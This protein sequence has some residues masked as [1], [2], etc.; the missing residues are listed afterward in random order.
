MQTGYNKDEVSRSLSVE[1]VARQYNIKLPNKTNGVIKCPLHHHDDTTPSFSID[2]EDGLWKSFGCDHSG[3]LYT[4]IAEMENLDVIDDFTYVLEKAADIAGVSRSETA[5]GKRGDKRQYE[6]EWKKTEKG[7]LTAARSVYLSKKKIDIAALELDIRPNGES[8]FTIPIRNWRGE[9]IGLQ[10]GC[11]MAVSG[12]NA[13]GFFFEKIN[14]KKPLYVV[15]GLSDYL[16][17]IASGLRNTIGLFSVNTPDKE[18]QDILSDAHDI[19]IC[20]DYDHFDA[21]GA[22]RGSDAGLK[23]TKKILQKITHAKAYFAS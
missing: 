1:A 3:D 14:R 4:L 22:A 23:K 15:E 10:R 7:D 20:L 13:G 12:S 18:I 17:M 8:D 19:K 9:I 21:T 11:K 5:Q 2:F 6:D 16:S